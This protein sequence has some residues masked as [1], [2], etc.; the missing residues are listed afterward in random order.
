MTM[1]TRRVWIAGCAL[2]IA[3][4]LVLGWLLGAAPLLEV[5]RTAGETRDAARAQNDLYSQELAALKEQYSG[6][7]QLEA[8]LVDLREELPAGVNQPNY[9]EDLAAAAQRHSVALTSITLSDAVAYAPTVAE[10][11][12]A[13]DEATSD[14]V[15]GAVEDAAAEAAP[16]PVDEGAGVP[17]TSPLVTAEN[18]V[19]IP[20]SLAL[21]GGYGN[22]LDFLESVQKGTRL[23]AVTAF[24]TSAD[25]AEAVDGEPAGPGTV[26]GTVT[27]FVYVLL[28]PTAG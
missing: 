2:V 5:A 8:D 10:A 18:F 16:T 23:S 9:L 25:S 17:V 11:P 24:S 22:V 13:G 1:S 28:D 6:I 27:M 14:P 15:E 20:V 26:T 21:Q 4:A 3:A 7:G 19:A 12:P